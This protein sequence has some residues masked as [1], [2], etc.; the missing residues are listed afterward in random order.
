MIAALS[1]FWENEQASSGGSTTKPKSLTYSQIHASWRHNVFTDAQA[2]SE[3]EG[4]GYSAARA[5]TLLDT[6]KAQAAAGS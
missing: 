5:Q 2:L 1:T 4:I 6:W 3:L